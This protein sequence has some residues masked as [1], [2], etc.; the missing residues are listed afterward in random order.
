MSLQ[1]W[2]WQLHIS[3]PSSH[4]QDYLAKL[5]PP[6]NEKNSFVSYGLGKW[7]TTMS[8]TLNRNLGP[9]IPFR[10]WTWSSSAG[11]WW[12]A[13]TC[14]R[15]PRGSPTRSTRRTIWSER[16]PCTTKLHDIVTMTL[17]PD[18]Y[19]RYCIR[20]FF[21]CWWHKAKFQRQRRNEQITQ[22]SSFSV[23]KNL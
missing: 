4:P 12:S 17:D 7:Q 9:E 13:S 16:L 18:F 11:C 3:A 23:F 10:T 20:V 22:E 15:K 21:I 6:A 19:Y 2:L 14:A 5:V 1:F 8:N